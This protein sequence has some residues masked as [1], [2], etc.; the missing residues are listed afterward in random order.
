LLNNIGGY[1]EAAFASGMT[2]FIDFFR[3]RQVQDLAEGAGANF[4][5]KNKWCR[6]LAYAKLLKLASVIGE[7]ASL[8]LGASAGARELGK[9]GAFIRDADKSWDTLRKRKVF[10]EMRDAYAK[11]KGL[12]KGEV[13][14][15]HWLIPNQDRWG[16][17]IPDWIKNQPWNLK[18][19]ASPFNRFEKY[20]MNPLLRAWLETPDWFKAS[21]GGVYMF[22]L[23][24]LSDA[25]IAELEKR[26]QCEKA[27]TKR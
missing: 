10:Q 24:K 11:E 26:C 8:G 12:G 23:D 14:L 21:L 17:H 25:A 6:L 20:Q 19:Q 5:S 2:A 15:D 3:A 9:S 22:D 27:G 18:P 4:D 13:D 1:G 7:N 16:K